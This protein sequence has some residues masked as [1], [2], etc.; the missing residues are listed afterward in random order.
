MEVVA[1]G[2]GGADFQGKD[3]L[4]RFGA[5]PSAG[6]GSGL[7]VTGEAWPVSGGE[8]G[9]GSKAKLLKEAGTA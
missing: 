6:M 8:G 9:S 3:C 7:R 5:V 1:W 4:F 2:W